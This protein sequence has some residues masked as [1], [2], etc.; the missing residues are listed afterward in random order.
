MR[1]QTTREL[2]PCPSTLFL[3]QAAA[4]DT[5][6]FQ[7]V[8]SPGSPGY[9]TRSCTEGQGQSLQLGLQHWTADAPRGATVDPE[10]AQRELE[11][12]GNKRF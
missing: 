11:L 8:I 6:G 7:T 5:S 1:N 9:G 3:P 12:D 10:H 2:R 4:L